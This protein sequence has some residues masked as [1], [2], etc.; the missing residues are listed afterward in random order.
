MNKYQNPFMILPIMLLD[1]GSNTLVEKQGEM[2]PEHIQFMHDALYSGTL[3]YFI[4]GGYLLC[5]ADRNMIKHNIA[6]YW[7]HVEEHE[8]KSEK[9]PIFTLQ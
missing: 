1:P 2:L 3:I 9:A 7:K 4:G 8:R 6:L 5:P